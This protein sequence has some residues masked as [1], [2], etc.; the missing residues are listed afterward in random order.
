MSL[1]EEEKEEI[2]ELCCSK[3]LI[4]KKFENACNVLR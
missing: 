2:E 4:N 3:G 1:E